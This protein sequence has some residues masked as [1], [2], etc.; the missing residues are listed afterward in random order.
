MMFDYQSMLIAS[1]EHWEL[2]LHEEAAPYL[3]RCVVW[4]KRPQAD[5]FIDMNA[6]ESE[7]LRAIVALWLEAL[8][9]WLASEGQPKPYRE[10]VSILGNSEPHLHA[11]LIP[12]YE[13]PVEVFGITFTDPRPHHHYKPYERVTVPDEGIE[14]IR[15]ALREHL[16]RLT[17]T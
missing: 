7:E 4:A 3:G 12:R 11:H 8:A 5:R 17:Q 6:E 14:K 1:F 16:S 9:D 15:D 13:E 2:Y 10:N